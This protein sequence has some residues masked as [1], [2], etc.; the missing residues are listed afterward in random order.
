MSIDWDHDAAQ[1][2]LVRMLTETRDLPGEV[3]LPRLAV[4]MLLDKI[5]E[6]KPRTI[7]TVEELD[8]LAPGSSVLCLDAAGEGH[9]AQTSGDGWGLPFSSNLWSAQHLLDGCESITV[10]QEWA[11]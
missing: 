1:A 4:N 11:A 10:I 7:T 2:D 3:R 8:A 5:V 9:P 6:L